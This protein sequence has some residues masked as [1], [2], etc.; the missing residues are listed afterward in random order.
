[1]SEAE[2]E[3]ETVAPD[4]PVAS[5][6]LSAGTDTTGAVVSTTVTVNEPL[7]LFPAPSV[8]VQWTV[9]VPSGN[10][11]PDPGPHDGATE[12]LTMSLAVDANETAAPEAPVASTVLLTGTDR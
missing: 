1:M 7:L 9:V 11:D 4:A 8:A 3:N 12:P 6:V 10:V 5:A 2:V